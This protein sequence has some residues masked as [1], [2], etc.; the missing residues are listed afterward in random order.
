MYEFL[1]LVNSGKRLQNKDQTV[2]NYLLYP[3]I[4]RLPSK[5][6]MFNYEDDIDI[7]FYLDNIRTKIPFNEIKDAL[8]NPTIIHNTICYPKP[9]Y[10]NSVYQNWAS[11]CSKRHNC[12]CKKYIDIWHSFAKKTDYYNEIIKFTGIK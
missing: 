6:G 12:S 2:I 1:D 3:K 11:A 5:Y 7:N 8:K 4:G 9:W 10:A